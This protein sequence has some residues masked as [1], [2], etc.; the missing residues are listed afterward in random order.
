MPDLVVCPCTGYSITGAYQFEKG[1]FEP[2]RMK[3]DFHLGKHHR[4]GFYMA[5]GEGI[6]CLGSSQ[7][8]LL[9]M[10]PTLLAYL[11][12]PV[13]SCMDGQVRREWFAPSFWEENPIRW[14]Q[15]ESEE[16]KT[17]ED[18][19][20]SQEAEKVKKRLEELGYL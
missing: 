11:G 20:T 6:Q 18:I 19:Y 17:S 8:S 10:A 16:Q 15:D 5:A 2:V 1:L 13:P 12:L 9:D 3:T 7:A 14:E 4:D